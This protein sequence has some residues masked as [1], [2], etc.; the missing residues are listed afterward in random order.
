MFTFFPSASLF[1]GRMAADGL[2]MINGAVRS[3]AQYIPNK[4]VKMVFC[5]TKQSKTYLTKYQVG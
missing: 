2:I 4:V 5:L 3:Q 1:F